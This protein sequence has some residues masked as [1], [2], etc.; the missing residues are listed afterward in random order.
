MKINTFKNFILDA[1][2]SLRRNKTI[3]IASSL[4]VAATL[5]IFGIFMLVGLTV[6]KQVE[7]IQ[8]KVEVVV[9][10]DELHMEI[11]EMLKINYQK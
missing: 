2:K 4:T 7:D 3:S 11:K 6:N 9:F 1:L 10:L 8:S 5:C